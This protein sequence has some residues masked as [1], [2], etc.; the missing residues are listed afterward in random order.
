M[1]KLKKCRDVS[2]REGVGTRLVGEVDGRAFV[3][4]GAEGEEGPE[5][6]W[7]GAPVAASRGYP[8]GIDELEREHF[9]PIRGRGG[10]G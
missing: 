10:R 2:F 5:G 4:E 1:Q 6:V 7:E 3:E 8:L 9:T